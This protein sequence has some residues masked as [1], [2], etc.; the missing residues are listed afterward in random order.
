M[1]LVGETAV[2]SHVS[3][4]QRDMGHPTSGNTPVRDAPLLAEVARSGNGDGQAPTELPKKKINP[5][6][7]KQMEDRVHELEEEISRTESAIAHLETALQSFVSAEETQRQSQELERGKTEHAKL[8][9]E[10]ES[11]SE[12]L[13]ETS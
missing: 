13:L 3:Q 7:R 2:P 12:S 8:V 4:K 10:W 6:R 11:L 5:I 9:E 1:E